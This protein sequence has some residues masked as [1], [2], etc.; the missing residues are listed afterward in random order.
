M[1]A[2]H[3][4][5]RLAAA[6]FHLPV[7]PNTGARVAHYERAAPL[8]SVAAAASEDED[9]DQVVRPERLA[10]DLNTN[11]SGVADHM[12]YEDFV[13]FS[14]VYHSNQEYFR[15]LEELKAAH[16]E[17]MAKLEKMYHNKLNLKEVQPVVVRENVP[18]VSSRSVSEKNYCHPVSLVASV[19]EPDLGC[20]SSCTS[21][22]EELPNLEKD[23]PGKT[24]AMSYARELINNMW[25][26]FRVQDY[27]RGED[28]DFPAVGKPK[29]KPKEWVPRITVPEPFQMMIRE[30]KRKETLK[31][32][33]DIEM[34]QTL[35][36]KEEE[37]KEF[38]TTFRA[39]PVPESVFL[40]LYHDLIK[41]NEER[42]RNIKE[43]SKA[44]LLA[45]QKPFKFMAREEQKQVA[46]DKQLRDYFKSKKKTYRFKARPVPRSIYG[47]MNSDKSKEE[48][49]HKNFKVQLKAQESLQNS[50]PLPRKSAY[51]RFRSPRHPDLSVK[52]KYKPKARS[53]P[54]EFE[55][56]AERYQAHSSEHR[57]SKLL[58]D[59]EQFDTRPSSSTINR[60]KVLADIKADEE[61]LKEAPWSYLS[62]RRKSQVRSLNSKPR[63]CKCNPPTPTMASKRR[64]E[65]IRRSLEEKKM[66]EE[67]RNRI[68]TKQ[69]ERMKE[70]QKLLTTRA[71]AYDS[72]QSLAQMSK[73]RLTYLRKSEKE[74]MRQYRQE[75]EEREEKLKTRPLLFERVAQNNAR[76]A[77]E[78]HYS[79]T[80]KA[81]GISDE[82]VSKKGQSRK[83]LEHFTSQETPSFSEDEESLHEEGDTEERENE[84]E[85]DSVDA[86]SQDSCKEEAEAEE[87]NGEEKPAE[88]SH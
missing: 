70:M 3:P 26:S 88:E 5:A 41:Q 2:S 87:A 28:A 82:F 72:H 77:A 22:E 49:R 60:E 71:K 81:L 86:D 56:S 83:L 58:T 42:K 46:R 35:L 14:D 25:T 38:K 47:S 16:I 24:R 39:N 68:L 17:T 34:V 33:S 75:L 73:S 43:K 10:A 63:P 55:D 85:N 13:N 52:L 54:P 21:S 79:N 7:N 1:A 69:K 64:G 9:D 36:K 50:S 74:R 45:S 20:S 6:S 51:K 12:N 76:L 15:K 48:D 66:L 27:I 80:L 78:K 59:F 30:Q 23:Y 57:D 44:A 4:V 32:K 40:P 31:S 61:G 8:N 29:R 65:A 37:E 67:E 62:P 11:Y 53:Q 18:S 84:E 19:S